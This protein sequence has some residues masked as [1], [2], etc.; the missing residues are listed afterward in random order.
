MWK[1]LFEDGVMKLWDDTRTLEDVPNVVQPFNPNG[2]EA[3][4]S[5][6]QAAEWADAFIDSILNPPVVEEPAP[7]DPAPAEETP[8]A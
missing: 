1:K 5:E 7:A 4:A 6:A 8:S 2:G 3:W